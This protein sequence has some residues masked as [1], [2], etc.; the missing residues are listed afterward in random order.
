MRALKALTTG[1]PTATA[2][3]VSALTAV[4][5]AA[6]ATLHQAMVSQAVVIHDLFVTALGSSTSSHAAIEAT[7][8]VTL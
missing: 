6:H 7:N 5:F 2:E 3:E 4:Q 1:V 8:M